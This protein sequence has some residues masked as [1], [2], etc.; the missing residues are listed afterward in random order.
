MVSD[1]FRSDFFLDDVVP[2][3]IWFVLQAFTFF[4]IFYPGYVFGKQDGWEECEQANKK[5]AKK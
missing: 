1:F 5:E 3:I 4:M 2:E